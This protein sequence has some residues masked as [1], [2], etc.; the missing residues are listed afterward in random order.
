MKNHPLKEITKEL[1]RRG[2]S[3][4]ELARRIGASS[5]SLSDVFN[6][7]NGQRLS[8]RLIREIHRETGVP[9]DILIQAY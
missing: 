3:R 1:K 2:M 6:Q 4:N 9:L 8:L 7:K 5:G